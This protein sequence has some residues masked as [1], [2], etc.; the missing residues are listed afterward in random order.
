MSLNILV[1]KRNNSYKK[2]LINQSSS[3]D[4]K[5]QKVN[6]NIEKDFIGGKEVIHIPQDFYSNP[7]EFVKPLQNNRNPIENFVKSQY[8][9]RNPKEFVET[10]YINHDP[11]NFVKSQ[12]N[13]PK[14]FVESQYINRDSKEFVEFQKNNHNQKEFVETQYINHDPKN[15]VKSQQNNPKEFVESQYINRDPKEF[16]KPQQNNH[17]Q[18]EFVETQYI[19]HDPKNFVKSQQNNPKEFVES[20]YINRDPKEFVEFQKNNRNPTE[21]FVKSKDVIPI[22]SK[23]V[24]PKFHSGFSKLKMFIMKHYNYKTEDEF[25]INVAILLYNYVDVYESRQNLRT[26]VALGIDEYGIL[27]EYF[28]KYSFVKNTVNFKQQNYGLKRYILSLEREPCPEYNTVT[29]YMTNYKN[30]NKIKSLEK[31]CDKVAKKIFFL[32]PKSYKFDY[33]KLLQRSNNTNLIKQNFSLNF[34]LIKKNILCYAEEIV[35]KKKYL[36]HKRLLKG[37]IIANY[38]KQNEDQKLKDQLKQYFKNEDLL[39][40]LID[41]EMSCKLYETFVKDTYTNRESQLINKL[42]TLHDIEDNL[43]LK[44]N[45]NK[46]FQE[47]DIYNDISVLE[48]ILL[49]Q[50]KL[51]YSCIELS[52]LEE[53]LYKCSIIKSKIKNKLI[54]IFKSNTT[55]NSSLVSEII[56][57]CKTKINEQD[58]FKYLPDELQEELINLK[59]LL[60]DNDVKALPLLLKD[61]YD[62]YTN[63]YETFYPIFEDI[64]NILSTHS[65]NT[66]LNE[67]LALKKQNDI[68]FEKNL[69]NRLLLIFIDELETHK[70]ISIILDDNKYITTSIEKNEQTIKIKNFLKKYYFLTDLDINNIGHLFLDYDNKLVNMNNK[71]IFIKKM[72][73]TRL[74]AIYT[75]QT[76]E[77]FQRKVKKL[78]INSV[79]NNIIMNTLFIKHPLE[80]FTIND[81]INNFSN[82]NLIHTEFLSNIYF[83]REFLNTDDKH[84]KLGESIGGAKGAKGTIFHVIG[85]D[86]ELIKRSNANKADRNLIEFFGHEVM[87]ILSLMFLDTFIK[88]SIIYTKNYYIGSLYGFFQMQRIFPN[89][90]K[91]TIFNKIN[92]ILDKLQHK[93]NIEQ[94]IPKKGD[95]LMSIIN[96]IN[97]IRLDDKKKSQIIANILI[98][99]CELLEKLQTS[100]GFIHC[101]MI[102]DNVLVDIDEDYKVNNI[103]IIDFELTIFKINDFYKL[104]YDKKKY[105]YN[106]LY[107]SPNNL[108]WKTIDIFFL[109]FVL[110]YRIYR[111]I[112]PKKLV[113][114]L[115]SNLHIKTNKT[116]TTKQNKNIY[117]NEIIPEKFQKFISETVLGLN[118]V[119]IYYDS[120]KYLDRTESYIHKYFHYSF[121]NE[122]FFNKFFNR[123]NQDN[124]LK[125]HKII[126]NLQP[127][128]LIELLKPWTI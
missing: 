122:E 21:N 4:C 14:E 19:N 8:I 115:V 7:K 83:A 81:C 48:K 127:L 104:S 26:N 30:E 82:E 126:Y 13:N 35:N 65:L 94:S 76:F 27:M 119:D 18:K 120:K 107:N 68:D 36:L 44:N 91:Q 102:L 6:Q 61:D 93:F 99:T 47:Y 54:Q 79:K 77:I 92:T 55:I 43:L 25:Y 96:N 45:L 85:N 71:K 62:K 124:P 87:K 39:Q 121:A 80:E 37:V 20:Q 29:S 66:E 42:I 50:F 58:G 59:T 90:N 105:N 23:N 110:F 5:L 100:I 95:T 101:D 34:D 109:I 3:N 64:I 114:E 103:Y 113:K 11:K 88:N 108:F 57:K 111:K 60:N 56:N 40:G 1:K 9:N 73:Y 49:Q 86:N 75:S 46:I 63:E 32:N 17:N 28:I 98:K 78:L 15:F 112:Y 97:F 38:L 10:Q 31:I 67:L 24:I 2:Q 125:H 106:I 74:M 118:N 12:Q 70:N 41:K 52:E 117:L 22:K 33:F 72:L 84:P 128:N 69:S 16:V 123:I 116:E 89:K 51:Y 53:A